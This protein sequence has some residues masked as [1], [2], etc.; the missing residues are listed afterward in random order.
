MTVLDG[1]RLLWCLYAPWHKWVKREPIGSVERVTCS[2]GQVYGINYNKQITFVVG[3][4]HHV[5][6]GDAQN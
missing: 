3:S 4:Y 5:E 6:G 2:C 1:F